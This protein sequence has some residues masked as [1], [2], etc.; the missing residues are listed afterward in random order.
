M[1]APSEVRSAVKKNQTRPYF[2]FSH[3]F[4]LF[5]EVRCDYF[6]L[7]WLPVRWSPPVKKFIDRWWWWRGE[8]EEARKVCVL[9]PKYRA[10]CQHGL[11]LFL[12]IVN[13]YPHDRTNESHTTAASALSA[14]TNLS[15]DRY[16]RGAVREWACAVK[17]VIIACAN[18]ASYYFW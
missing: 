5:F 12:Y 7:A 10:E 3:V 1:L 16:R 15:T 8:K 11:G 18:E 17:S 9:L 6:F 13:I 14:F 4:I 2:F